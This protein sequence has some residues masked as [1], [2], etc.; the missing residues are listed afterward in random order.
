LPQDFLDIGIYTIK[1]AQ[2][3]TGVSSQRI[4][5][6]LQGYNQ[7]KNL[8]GQLPP[9][10]GK[11][12][13]G[14]LDLM[15]VRFIDHFLKRGVKW[16]SIN[17]AAEKA[18]KQFQS[19]HPFASQYITDGKDI[20]LQTNEEV[21]DPKL[22]SLVSNQFALYKILEPLL[23]EG[24]DFDDAGNAIRWHPDTHRPEIIVDPKRAFGQPILTKSGIPTNVLFDAFKVEGDVK[25][26]AHWYEISPEATIQAIEFEMNLAA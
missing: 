22:E 11:L 12:A 25:K 7:K 9:I 4:R 18:R 13:L 20:F 2:R 24:L 23:L 21:D 1:D 14:F 19:K 6:W 17:I 26:V 3:L 5:G 16:K 15:E 10:D 8:T